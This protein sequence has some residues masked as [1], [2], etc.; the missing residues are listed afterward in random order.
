MQLLFDQTRVPRSTT[1]NQWREMD[2]WRRVTERKLA[3]EVERKC[4]TLRKMTEQFVATGSTTVLL[5][6]VQDD[7]IQHLVFPP[8]LLGPHQEATIRTDK[9]Q[10]GGWLYLGVRRLPNDDVPPPQHQFRP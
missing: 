6:R 7:I 2:R 5:Q 9:L 8:L 4:D 3:V 1:R 10:P